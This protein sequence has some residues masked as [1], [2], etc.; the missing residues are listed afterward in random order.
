[1][2]HTN[3]TMEKAQHLAALAQSTEQH[4][5]LAIGQWQMTP[6]TRFARIPAAGS[7]SANQCLQHLN[8]YARYY[9]PRLEAAFRQAAPQSAGAPFR[10]G[11]LG[12]WF[13]RMMQPDATTG[14]PAKPMQAPAAHRP[15]SIAPS[16]EVIGEFIDHL[17]HLLQLLATAE[18][19]NITRTR[20][21]ISIAPFI[22][23][24]AGDI[25][26]FLVAHHERHVQQ[27]LRALT[28]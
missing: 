21:P 14:K 2:K 25:L 8:S 5:Q 26:A 23:L 7:W 16:H 19:V 9:L 1:M 4:L 18:K 10:P 20:I 11:W 12:G 17:E 13:T 15:D 24:Q 3:G 27:A 22:R 6:H 28:A